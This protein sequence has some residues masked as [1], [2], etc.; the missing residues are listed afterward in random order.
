MVTTILLIIGG[1]LLEVLLL[2]VVVHYILKRISAIKQPPPE[3]KVVG[4]PI[5][6]EVVRDGVKDAIREI[7]IEEEQRR[8]FEKKRRLPESVHHTG[9]QENRVPR[10]GGN[11][12]PYGLTDQE[13]ELLDMFYED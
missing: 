9:Q 1:V 6:S 4:R 2:A 12:I 3:V 13:K 5:T 8:S 10:S 11:L 7:S